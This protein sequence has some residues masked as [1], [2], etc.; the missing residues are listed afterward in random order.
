MV[1]VFK[2]V[3]KVVKQIPK[4]KV[5][6]YGWVAKKLGIKDVRVVGWALHAND[7]YKKVPCYRVVKKDGSLAD[8]YAHGGAKKQKQLLAAEGVRFEKEG[9]V[10]KEFFV[11]RDV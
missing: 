7:D 5:V 9:R 1:S 6:S 11:G 4:G 10:E 2:R 3:Y 8:N